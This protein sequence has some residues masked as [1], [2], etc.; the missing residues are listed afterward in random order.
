MCIF[1]NVCIYCIVLYIYCALSENDE[2]KMINQYNIQYIEADT[3]I[4]WYP[5]VYAWFND[6]MATRMD[7]AKSDWILTISKIQRFG[8]GWK[9]DVK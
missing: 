6:C 9:Y 1:Y 4:P 5:N 8:F 7:E 2:I 3:M